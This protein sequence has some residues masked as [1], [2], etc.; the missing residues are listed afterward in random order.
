MKKSVLLFATLI[1]MSGMTY[2]Q[3]LQKGNLIGTHVISVTLQPGV[4]I[5]KFIDFYKSKVVPEYGKAFSGMK[6]YIVKSVRGENKDSFGG[7]MVFKTEAD[8]DK[9]F[10]ADGSYTE[11]GDAAYAKLKPVLD[12]LSKLGTMTSVY[13]DWLVL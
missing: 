9:Y 13:N 10:K 4:T 1:L 2:G 3:T 12:E 6:A 11:I 5:E 8:R 7:F